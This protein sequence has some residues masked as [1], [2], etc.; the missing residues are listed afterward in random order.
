MKLTVFA[1]GSRGDIQPCVVLSRGLQQ[2]GYAVQLAAPQDFAGFVQEQGVPFVP[3]RGDVQAVMAGDTGREFMEHGGGN[4]KRRHGGS[5]LEAGTVG[6]MMHA[7]VAPG[8]RDPPGAR[9]EGFGEEHSMDGTILEVVPLKKLRFT[10]GDVGE[11]TFLL[12]PV[13]NDVRLTLVQHRTKDRNQRIMVG[14]GWHAHLAILKA[15]LE[16]RQPAEGFWD[17]WLRLKADYEGMIKA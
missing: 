4:P 8:P 12:E 3:L 15:K 17:M 5:G 6:T 2:A 14:A 16:D 1:A 13:G 7:P 10:W 9:P 11:V